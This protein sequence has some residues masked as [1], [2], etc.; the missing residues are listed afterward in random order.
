MVLRKDN[1]MKRNII[2]TTVT[3]GAKAIYDSLHPRTKGIW[4]S[5]AIITKHAQ[6]SGAGLE[7]R[8]SKL[9]KRVE[10]LEGEKRK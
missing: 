9:E 1:N 2:N 3:P 8:V 10:K 4:L 5:D 7:A 6:D